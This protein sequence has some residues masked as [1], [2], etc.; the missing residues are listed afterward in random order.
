MAYTKL[1]QCLEDLKLYLAVTEIEPAR[2][3]DTITSYLQKK[4]RDNYRTASAGFRKEA[5]GYNFLDLKLIAL[6]DHIG[7]TPDLDH[8]LRFF[9]QG[10]KQHKIRNIIRSKPFRDGRLHFFYPLF[11]QKMNCTSD[12][13]DLIKARGH[14]DSHDLINICNAVAKNRWRRFLREAQQKRLIEYSYG[15][16]R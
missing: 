10:N 5:K 4:I 16:W 9:Q 15:G 11:P 3:G 1:S 7:R 8:L 12:L 6:H 2:E 14:I 13:V